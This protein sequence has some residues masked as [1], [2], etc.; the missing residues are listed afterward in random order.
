[1]VLLAADWVKTLGDRDRR[2]V[3]VWIA[4]GK[5][6]YA[7]SKLAHPIIALLD[8]DIHWIFGVCRDGTVSV[9][10]WKGDRGETIYHFG[11]DEIL[12]LLE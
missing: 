3:Q 5:A 12:R 9:Y 10:D 2:R 6:H 7:S 8:G 4:D 11:G 1:M